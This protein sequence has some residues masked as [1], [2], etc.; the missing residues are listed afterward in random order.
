MIFE[1]KYQKLLKDLKKEMFVCAKKEQF[2]LA[3]EIKQ[4]VFALEHIQ[5]ISL[6]KRDLSTGNSGNDFRIEAYDVAHISGKQMVGVMTVVTNA[7]AD[8]NEYRKFVIKGFD[9]ANDAGALKEVLTRRFA[10]PEWAM[11]S[12]I[13]VDGNIIQTNVAQEVLARLK[14]KMPIIAVTKD[15]RHRPKAITGSKE[16]VEARKYDIL[17]ANSEAHRFAVSFHKQRRQKAFK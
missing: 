11:P 4:K 7:I 3:N 13:V 14:L 16:L 2:E 8:K 5:D 17:L 6:I 10:H 15:E 12:A 1:G 9:K